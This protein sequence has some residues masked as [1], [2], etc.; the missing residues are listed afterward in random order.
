[1]E[2]LVTTNEKLAK[3][4]ADAN[5]AIARLCLSAPATAPAGSSNDCPSHWSP[6][7]PDWDPTGYCS[8]HKFKVKH[9]HTSATCAH[10]KEGHNATA[11][12]LDAK[13]VREA[14]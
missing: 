7:I 9:G 14:N 3:A 10:S 11:T 6:V 1:M 13:G 2:K 5:A 4:L 8:L 12:R